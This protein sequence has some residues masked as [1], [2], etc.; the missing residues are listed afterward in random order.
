[1]IVVSGWVPGRAVDEISRQFAQYL[2][3]AA[4]ST[5]SLL[6]GHTEISMQKAIYKQAFHI[7][8]WSLL[9][10]GH[11]SAK[12]FMDWV[13][14]Q[15]IFLSVSENASQRL[16]QILCSV[17]SR[18]HLHGLGVPLTTCRGGCAGRKGQVN[19][20]R[21]IPPCSAVTA[22]HAAANGVTLQQRCGTQLC[23][24]KRTWQ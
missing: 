19:K 23:L 17:K 10:M 8:T 12:I 18:C 4:F 2:K 6:K 22:R 11:L 20:K 21:I 3:K 24:R 15:Q 14:S 13:V 7:S 1:M 5:F 16:L 9:K